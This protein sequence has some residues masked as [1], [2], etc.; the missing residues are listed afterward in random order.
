[1]N[2]QLL[3]G[4]SDAE[5]IQMRQQ[6]ADG[7]DEPRIFHSIWTASAGESS[8]SEATIVIANHGTEVVDVLLE[9]YGSQKQPLP[10]SVGD[11]KTRS[12]ESRAYAAKIPAS[13][14]IRAAL[15]A[16]PL[17]GGAWARL[18]SSSPD[19]VTAS[20]WV[21][22]GSGAG[23]RTA[24][25]HA[26]PS[27]A[28]AQAVLPGLQNTRAEVV[29]IN[30]SEIDQEVELL[31]RDHAGEDVCEAT[32]Q[33]ASLA[34]VAFLLADKLTCSNAAAGSLSISADGDGIAVRV[35]LTDSLTREVFALPLHVEAARENAD[36][37]GDEQPQPPIASVVPAGNCVPQFSPLQPR[38]SSVGQVL[39]VYLDMRS[40]SPDQVWVVSVDSN[41]NL[42]YSIVDE[43]NRQ[44]SALT[45]KGNTTIRL[46][47]N[48][49]PVRPAGAR[50]GS[51]AVKDYSRGRPGRTLAT[52]RF[53]QPYSLQ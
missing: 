19:T 38:L 35:Q 2:A 28:H 15:L 29:I 46:R 48:Q 17:A 45:G 49:A 51:F 27:H 18:F 53:T 37:D 14:F 3:R 20:M 22:S 52:Y 11:G 30:P 42:W 8:S 9:V 34:R 1:M 33:V 26:E 36:G 5:T 23:A 40:C 4:L 16:P 7:A 47:L 43:R 21:A 6:L 24:A 50:G 13:G 39:S 12:P 31:L 25:F 41:P 10:F 32:V 44:V